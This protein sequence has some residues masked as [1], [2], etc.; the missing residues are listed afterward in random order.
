MARNDLWRRASR[1]RP[2]SVCCWHECP[3]PGCRTHPCPTNHVIA[4]ISDVRHVTSYHTSCTYVMCDMIRMMCAAACAMTYDMMRYT[5]CDMICDAICDTA[6]VR[7]NPWR[8]QGR[9][10]LQR[11]C[12]WAAGTTDSH[13]ATKRCRLSPA[14]HHSS[15]V[16]LSRPD[17]PHQNTKQKQSRRVVRGHQLMQHSSTRGC[18]RLATC[19]IE[20]PACA[21]PGCRVNWEASRGG[22]TQRLRSFM[23]AGLLYTARGLCSPDPRQRRTGSGP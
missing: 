1:D 3:R 17:G 13:G 20:I 15:R 8:R 11:M 4:H 18:C 16:W 19:L 9:G 21:P 10:S 23:H 14:H 7:T 12:P 5:I 6:C 22:T 2:T